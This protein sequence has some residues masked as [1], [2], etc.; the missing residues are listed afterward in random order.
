MQGMYPEIDAWQWKDRF[1]ARLTFLFFFVYFGSNIFRRMLL[2]KFSGL[3]YFI[4]TVGLLLL[5]CQVISGI[6]WN[7]VFMGPG[8]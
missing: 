1:D 5:I 2:G 8:T 7:H 6:K 3:F 4:S